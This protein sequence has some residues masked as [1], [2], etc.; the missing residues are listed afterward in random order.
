MSVEV[1]SW[2]RFPRSRSVVLPLSWRDQPIPS[3]GS[4]TSFLPHGMGRSYGDSCLNDGNTLLATRGLDRLITFNPD[5]GRLVAEA[6]ITFDAVLQFAIPRG[7]FLPVTPGTRFVTLGGAIANDVHG[8]NHHRAGTFGDHVIRFELRRSD[9]S[10]LLCSAEENPGWFRATVGGLGLTGLIEWAE[11]QLKPISNSFIDSET[12][13]YGDLDEFF[14]LSSESEANYEYVVAW[15]DSLA[16]S[17]L[18]RGRFIRGNHNTDPDRTGRHAPNASKLVVPFNVPFSL[19]NRHTL[20]LFNTAYY[21]SKFARHSIATV[22]LEPF[23]YP[24]DAI[25]QWNRIYGRGGLI[26]WQA[27]IPMPHR[28]A[29]REILS[30]AARSG[31]G[32]FLTVMKVMGDR[33]PAGLLSFSGHGITI[34]LD[35]PYDSG[36]INVLTRMND[37][38]AEAKGR[39]YP[40]KDATM[41]AQHFRRFYPQW[42]SLLPYVDPRFSS[43]FWR[44]VTQPNAT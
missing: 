36:L 41:S 5:S 2:G 33:P 4:N 10:R 44:R 7:W 37:I 6:G 1:Q 14:T 12:I 13:R 30:L 19:L 39:L 23:F 18:G 17:R 29:S 42:E 27:L 40:A 24:L 34:A 35:F 25:A 9:G 31:S 16:I 28:N 3:N 38:V 21:R 22:P 11:V 32:S 43:S 8:K 20:K 26:Q 15:V